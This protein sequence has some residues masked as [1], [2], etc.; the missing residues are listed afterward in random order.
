MVRL[1]RFAAGWSGRCAYERAGGRGMQS[2]ASRRHRAARRAQV[3]V[4]Q[5]PYAGGCA[6]LSAA[7][8]TTGRVGAGRY[9]ADSSASPDAARQ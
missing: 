4:R 6:G 3:G 7:R 2:S 5:L 8:T 1:P 9:N